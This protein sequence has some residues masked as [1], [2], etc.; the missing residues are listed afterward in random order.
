SALKM[1][2]NADSANTFI[3]PGTPFDFNLLE[4]QRNKI[5]N[6]FRNEGYYFISNDEVSYLADSSKFDREI[7]LDLF[8]G[9]TPSTQESE[10]FIPYYLDQFYISI[11][12]GSV[13]ISAEQTGNWNYADT[14]HWDNH[15]LYSNPEFI[16]RTGLFRSLLHMEHGALYRMDDARHTFN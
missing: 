11:L 14:L 15:T 8:I 7:I 6:L 16:Y 5:V 9:V 4:E 3:K 1:L 12:P 2:F 10:R 13:P